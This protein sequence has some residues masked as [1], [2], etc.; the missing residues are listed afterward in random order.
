MQQDQGCDEFGDLTS[1]V[2]SLDDISLSDFYEFNK[3][4]FDKIGELPHFKWSYSFNDRIN[5]QLVR[6]IHINPIK[7]CIDF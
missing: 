2:D 5:L 3:V 7:E 1:Y 6:R 4:N